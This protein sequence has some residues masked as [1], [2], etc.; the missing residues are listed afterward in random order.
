MSTA[1]SQEWMRQLGAWCFNA[2]YKQ[3]KEDIYPE[4]TFVKVYVE[5]KLKEM[6]EDPFLWI[7]HL[8]PER[9]TGLIKGVKRYAEGVRVNPPLRG[10]PQ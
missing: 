6:R 10:S 3:F 2:G 5:A 4:D 9:F 7:S 8:D 1:P